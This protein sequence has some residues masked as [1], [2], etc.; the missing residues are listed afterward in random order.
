[1]RGKYYLTTSIG[2]IF[3]LGYYFLRKK[4]RPKNI[5][6][7]DSKSDVKSKN[8]TEKVVIS[9][10]DAPLNYSEISIDENY[11][12][13]NK[14]KTV[15]VDH[16]TTNADKNVELTNNSKNKITINDDLLHQ[17]INEILPD[18]SLIVNTNSSNDEIDLNELSKVL[19]VNTDLVSHEKVKNDEVYPDNDKSLNNEVVNDISKKLNDIELL[20]EFENKE[21]NT[22][23]TNISEFANEYNEENLESSFT[24]GNVHDCV[25]YYDNI[26]K[27]S[28]LNNSIDSIKSMRKE[29]G[30]DTTQS[31]SES[32]NTCFTKPSLD[33]IDS[34][35]SVTKVLNS[36]LIDN[37]KLQKKDFTIIDIE[38]DFT[39]TLDNEILNA[40]IE[41]TIKSEDVDL[42][43]ILDNQISVDLPDSLNN[44]DNTN[45][46]II[47]DMCESKE[48][49]NLECKLESSNSLNTDP[50]QE[51]LLD[52]ISNVSFE[53]IV[54]IFFL[55]CLL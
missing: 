15:K 12:S 40:N 1:M 48:V 37:E 53:N 5:P 51:V 22:S 55:I 19:K 34:E 27:T 41:E 43:E 6:D 13:E 44:S 25:I 11:K 50:I 17:N 54:I 29:N 33:I 2:I 38:S 23:H 20:N 47:S 35:V 52:S 4:K 10:K 46:S 18:I 14:I 49:N 7:K 39:E 24:I 26:S 42:N 45:V 30:L 9:K 8:D 3:I 16:C 32:L 28:E 36:D 31:N 21:D